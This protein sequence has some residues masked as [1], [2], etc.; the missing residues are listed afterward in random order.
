MVED[1]QKCAFF[2][3]FWLFLP[4]F[5]TFIMFLGVFYAQTQF[6]ETKKDSFY[7]YLF[8]KHSDY[9]VLGFVQNDFKHHHIHP[10]SHLSIIRR[11]EARKT[12]STCCPTQLQAQ[13]I[14]MRPK[15]DLSD[16][17]VTIFLKC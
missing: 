9:Q 10:R 14:H 8:F 13:A 6:L 16:V 1:V 15:T 3:R 12:L 17:C 5:M 4:F 2:D 11:P 7:G